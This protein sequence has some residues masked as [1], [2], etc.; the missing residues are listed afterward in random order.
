MRYKLAIFDLDGT[1]LDTIRDLAIAM[2]EARTRSGLPEQPVEKVMAMVGNGIRNLIRRST[3]AEPFADR[4]KLH[5]DFTEYYNGHCLENTYPYRGIP[6]MLMSL[7]A[8]GMKLAVLSNKPDI[9]S[10]K[11]V[12][13][14]F[15]GLFDVVRGNV[16]DVPLKPSREG[17]DII[18]ETLGISAED[19]VYIG[20]SEV[21]IM[22]AQNSGLASISVDWGFKTR[23]FLLENDAKMIFSSPEDLERYLLE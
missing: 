12:G 8:S 9:P 1:I 10:K 20:D 18:L 2:N 11:L 14:R 5:S 23:D 7:K 4:E 22:T 15:P 19:A 6:E 3:A 17:V 21:D 13:E 16:E